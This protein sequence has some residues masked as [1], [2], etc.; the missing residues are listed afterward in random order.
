MRLNINLA[1][2]PYEVA[3]EYKR[4]MTVLIAALAVVAVVLVGY[5]VY[6]RAHSRSINRQLADVQAADRRAQS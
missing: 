6:Q 4:R 2:Q 3:R 5:I 1:S